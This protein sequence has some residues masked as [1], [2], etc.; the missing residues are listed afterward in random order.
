MSG[1]L[2]AGNIQ[3]ALLGDDG[4]FTGYMGVKNTVK[5]AIAQ[6]D[7]NEKT[8]SSKMIENYGQALDTVYAPGADKLTIDLDEHD[9]DI[10]GMAFRGT[11]ADLIASALA[12]QVVTIDVIKG[13][14]LPIKAGAYNLT[15]VIVIE[16]T[17]TDPQT[18]ALGTDYKLDAAGGMIFIDPD[19]TIDGTT[20]KIT[21]SAPAIAGKRVTPGTKTTLR[22][23][24]FGRMKNMATGRP[25]IVTVPDASLYPASDVDFLADAFAVHSLAGTMK[26]IDGQPPYLIDYL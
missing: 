5:L 9:A 19:G 18:Y 10:A 13:V 6:A 21:I 4:S 14:W 16:D 22:A 17:V 15:D 11:V 20:L 23:R 2:C 25:L 1:L 7:N 3:I 12:A 8:R 26:A 24:I